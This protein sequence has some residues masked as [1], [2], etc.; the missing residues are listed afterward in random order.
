M[1][2]G[3][4][5]RGPVCIGVFGP[6][7]ARSHFDCFWPRAAQ[8]FLLPYLARK[9]HG[10]KGP[11]FCRFGSPSI[12]AGGKGPPK[13]K[14]A[15]RIRTNSAAHQRAQATHQPSPPCALTHHSRT[16][17][18]RSIGSELGQAK[19]I[20]QTKPKVHDHVAFLSQVQLA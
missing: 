17:N 7:S 9:F 4:C 15:P 10:S 18:L 20:N 14:P 13:R 16:G 12:F 2:S 19:Q 1:G 8:R 3:D 6:G 11:H 5:G